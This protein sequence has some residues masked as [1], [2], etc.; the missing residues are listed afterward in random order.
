MRTMSRWCSPDT[1]TSG[2]RIHAEKTSPYTGASASMSASARSPHQTCRSRDPV[3]RMLCAVSF[4]RSALA[5]RLLMNG[6]LIIRVL[7][8]RVLI[9]R[10]LIMRVVIIRVLIMRVVIRHF[11]T[12]SVFDNAFHHIRDVLTRDVC[13]TRAILAWTAWPPPAGHITQSGFHPFVA[14]MTVRA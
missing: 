8:I 10:V 12:T 6:V 9:I 11:L 1:D 4:A 2:I 3:F 7:I 13:S 5:W 14:Y